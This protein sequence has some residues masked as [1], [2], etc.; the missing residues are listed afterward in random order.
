MAYATTLVAITWHQG[1]Y[2]VSAQRIGA[3]DT[4]RLKQ[5]GFLRDGSDHTS[6][7]GDLI[8]VLTPRDLRLYATTSDTEKWLD[9]LPSDVFVVLVHQGEWESGLGD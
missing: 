5:E 6:G 8:A 4:T 2:A 9:E 3:I 7:Y 1:K